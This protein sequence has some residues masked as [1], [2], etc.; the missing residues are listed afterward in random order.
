MPNECQEKA[1][2]QQQKAQHQQLFNQ[3]AHL[4]D[5]E[6]QGH[7][8]GLYHGGNPHPARPAAGHWSSHHALQPTEDNSQCQVQCQVQCH[9]AHQQHNYA[10]WQMNQQLLCGNGAPPQRCGRLKGEDR[11]LVKGICSSAVR[12]STAAQQ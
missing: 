7:H 3:S 12:S 6:G 8:K 2:I 5:P 4:H 9:P 11:A 1:E 10:T